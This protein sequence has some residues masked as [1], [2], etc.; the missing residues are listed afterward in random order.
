MVSRCWL[1]CPISNRAKGLVFILVVVSGF[2]LTSVDVPMD[3]LVT[4]VNVMVASGTL[5]P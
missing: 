4:L 3:T 2:M 5:G 1:F